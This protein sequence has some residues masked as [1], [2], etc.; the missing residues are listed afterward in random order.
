[1]SSDCDS[2][3]EMTRLARSLST[4]KRGVV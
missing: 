1:M 3:L 2:P 4:K